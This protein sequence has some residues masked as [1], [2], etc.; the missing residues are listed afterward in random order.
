MR[1]QVCGKVPFASPD[2]ARREAGSDLKGRGRPYRCATCSTSAAPVFHL[3]TI[4]KTRLRQVHRT[5]ER[6]WRESRLAADRDHPGEHPTMTDTSAPA[7]GVPP[8]PPS[9]GTLPERRTHT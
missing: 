5:S 7:E 9:P 3:T 4:S 8:I 1:V 6:R 2:A